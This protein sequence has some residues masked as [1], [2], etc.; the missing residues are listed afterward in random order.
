MSNSQ[1]GQG[2]S[3][4]DRHKTLSDRVKEHPED[5]QG[6]L[7]FANFLFDHWDAP[8]KT[9][10]AY[11]RAQRLLPHL[12]LRLHHGTALVNAGRA[13]EGIDLIKEQLSKKPTSYGYCML[14]QN[15]INLGLFSEAREAA[16]KA[17]ELEPDFDEAH[18]FLGEAYR[19]DDA[20]DKRCR[21]VAA[22]EHF[23][24]ALRLDPKVSA[25]W[26][27]LGVTLI[28]SGEEVE[29]GMDALRR[30]ISL[31]PD[32]GWSMLS[33]ANFLWRRGVL[34]EAE[35]FF[36]RSIA[37]FPDFDKPRQMY[38]DF[39]HSLGRFDEEKRIRF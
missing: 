18:F 36:K 31:N 7:E 39:L 25:T 15:L 4:E 27:S 33:L 20:L 13:Q 28:E 11:E 21:I 2:G 1:N 26:H 14:A 23:R 34:G 3:E 12:D 19:K 6:W 8:A 17:I 22:V 35:H 5:G 30:A 38:A 32:D 24:E 16:K 10:H 37:A 29:Q 9:A